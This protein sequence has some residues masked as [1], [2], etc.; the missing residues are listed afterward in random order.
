M[1]IALLISHLVLWV[2]VL[3]Q[4]V[5]L[6]VIVR[7][8]GLLY[9]R[10]G[11][12][13]AR[14]MAVGPEIGEVIDP[15]TLRDID[16]AEKLMTIGPTMDS[17]VLLLFVSP[18]CAACDTLIPALRPLVRETRGEVVWILLATSSSPEDCAL[19]RRNHALGFIFFAH[20]GLAAAHFEV[21][22]SPYAL[23]IRSDGVLIAKGL[24]NHVD[25]LESVLSV[26]Q[27]P[28][29]LQVPLALEPQS[30]IPQNLEV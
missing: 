10:N 27:R 3:A 11:A 22:G 21:G 4:M 6:L 5:V 16:D 1:S 2:L 30:P 24:V 26:R 29:A 12:S 7:Q 17:D 19:Y 25:Q 14:S 8:V 15:I 9:L 18:S 28:N 13:R 23:L 20:D